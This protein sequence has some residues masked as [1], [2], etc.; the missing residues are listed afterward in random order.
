MKLKFSCT[1]L[2]IFLVVTFILTGCS[3][4]NSTSKDSKDQVTIRMVWWG[5]KEVHERT[6]KVIDLF[7]EQNPDI[8][9][10]TEFTGWDGYWDKL[11]TQAA[12]QNI[13][14]V[15]NMDIQYLSEYVD[16]D[17]LLDL[18]P[19]IDKGILNFDDVDD[20][21]LDG[22]IIN[23]KLFAVNQGTNSPALTY[24]PE[25]LKEAGISE[26]EPGYTWDD[27]IDMAKKLK[28]HFGD[29]SYVSVPQGFNDFGYYLRQHGLWLYNEDGTGLGYDDDQYLV[30]FLE[31][32][33]KLR[34]ENITP[35]QDVMNSVQGLEDELI[36]HKTSPFHPLTSNEFTA[37]QQ[38]ADRPLE[39]TIFPSL[40]GGEYGQYLKPG[41]FYAVSSHSKHP[42]EAAKLVDF[43]TNSTEAHEILKAIYGVPISSKV[44]E[45]I[46]P[47]VDEPTKQ[48]FDYIELVKDYSSPIS[49]PEP[50]GHGEISSMYTR[51]L[52]K[53]NFGELTPEDAAKQ[54]RSEAEARL[55]KNTKD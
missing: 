27:F 53:I 45:H 20:S 36:V 17:L 5:N 35:P 48:I 16:R 55:A 33:Q 14:D 13:P 34:E 47:L 31:M 50:S 54:F 40:E 11:A 18:N 19:Y 25:M 23:G 2:S 1:V 3:S 39:L 28:N 9:V 49:P 52:E 32:Q 21:L 51:V 4:S 10:S 29:D 24:D 46:T 42:E 7:E 15:V 22:G 26:I 30:D 43:F 37:I 8:K 38:A 6:Q 41:Q 12:G 44:Q